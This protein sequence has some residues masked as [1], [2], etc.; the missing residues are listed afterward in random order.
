[1]SAIKKELILIDVTRG[2]CLEANRKS[3]KS[4][5]GTYFVSSLKDFDK[6]KDFLDDE[7]TYELNLDKIYEYSILFKNLSENIMNDYNGKGIKF[8]SFANYLL[9][10]KENQ[11]V[12]I[13]LRINDSRV[14]MR[15]KDN[16]NSIVSAFRNLLYEDLSMICLEK[17][18][19][20]IEV[21][22]FLITNKLN[23]GK[24]IVDDG[25]EL[26]E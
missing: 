23:K 25:F 3:G 19:G 7:N 21:Y 1:M 16:N 22:P 8:D 17:I 12:E 6:F 11:K 20:I 18:N 2:D 13:T 10:F 26:D 24:E 9:S 5:T 15:F 14:F 4:N